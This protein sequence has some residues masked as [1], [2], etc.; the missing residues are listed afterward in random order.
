M[1]VQ[2]IYVFFS[3]ST[4]RWKILCDVLKRKQNDPKTRMLLPKKFSSAFTEIFED[5]E[6][7]KVVKLT[8]LLE[9]FAFS[10]VFFFF[11]SGDSSEGWR[12]SHC[13]KIFS[14]WER[15]RFFSNFGAKFFI[16]QRMWVQPYKILKWIFVL[17]FLCTNDWMLMSR[18]GEVRNHSVSWKKIVK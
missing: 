7:K 17:L 1:F 13:T 9:K 5:P 11:S 4:K 18:P 15:R 12:L 6:E 8:L 16:R 10:S 2:N 14:N 3:K